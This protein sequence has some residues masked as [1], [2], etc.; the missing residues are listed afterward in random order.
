MFKDY[1]DVLNVAQVCEMLHIGKNSAYKLLSSGEIK[2][3]RIG[4]KYVIPKLCVIDYLNSS[5]YISN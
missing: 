5:R 3:R 4:R 2:S 1:P